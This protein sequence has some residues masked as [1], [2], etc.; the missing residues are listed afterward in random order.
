MLHIF[1]I[2]MH[3]KTSIEAH[4]AVTLGNFETSQITK[5][6]CVQKFGGLSICTYCARNLDPET[7]PDDDHDGSLT[8]LD[9]LL[10]VRHSGN[11]PQT[12]L[13]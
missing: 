12:M 4:T 7:F 9:A 1:E 13:L 11:T 6:G 3:L 5:L 2:N 8:V 10:D